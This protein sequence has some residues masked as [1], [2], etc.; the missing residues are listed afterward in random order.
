MD[1]IGWGVGVMLLSSIVNVIVAK[2][3]FKVGK[4]TDSIALQ[5]DG[6]HL[7]TDVYTSLG[8]MTGLGAIWLG[9]IFFPGADLLWLDPAAAIAVALMIFKAAYEL[10]VQATRDLLDVSL[11]SE[12]E[13]WIMQQLRIGFPEAQGCHNFKTR[14]SGATRFIEFHLLVS[15]EMSVRE[16]HDITD[17]IT[18]SIREHFTDSEVMVH[19]EP[20]DGRCEP[21]CM[22]TCFQRSPKDAH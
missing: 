5:A 15:P 11:P 2:R 9:Q 16:S 20:C 3:L 13:E 17:Q 21:K 12:E 14:K 8:V 7:W 19:I 22:S 6:M 4:E 1:S 10:T 18:H